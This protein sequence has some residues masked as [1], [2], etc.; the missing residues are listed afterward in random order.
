MS[1][2]EDLQRFVEKGLCEGKFALAQLLKEAGRAP[3]SGYSDT[4]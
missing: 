4:T 1:S 2:G 3:E